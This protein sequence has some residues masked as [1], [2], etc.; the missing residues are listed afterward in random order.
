MKVQIWSDIICPFCYIGK[1][2][3]EQALE[4]F[5]HADDIEIQWRSFQLQPDL[6]SKGTRNQYEQLAEIKGITLE[7]SKKMHARITEKARQAGLEYDF[8]NAIPANTF[9]A[10]RLSRLAA[11]YGLQDEAEERLFSAHFTE[12]KDIDNDETLMELGTEISLPEE[13]VNQLLN[14]DLYADGVKEDIEKARQAGVQGV[15]FF[16]LND[17]YAVS[18]A[19][20]SEALLEALQ[21]AYAEFEKENRPEV[22]DAAGSGACTIDGNCD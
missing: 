13:E 2:N 19:Q 6:E 20:P 14:S 15:P 22:L 21:K 16:V 5:D 18:G 8:D 10:H 17:K 3:F 12:G 11:E 9:K 1:R 4:Q 7:Q